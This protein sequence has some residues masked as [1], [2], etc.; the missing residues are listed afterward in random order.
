MQRD[1]LIFGAAHADIYGDVAFDATFTRSSIKKR[2]GNVNFSLG[3]TGFNV[4]LMLGTRRLPVSL[5]YLMNSHYFARSLVE[6]ELH[7]YDVR[8]VPIYSEAIPHVFYISHRMFSEDGMVHTHMAVC[9]DGL[10]DFPVS[11][12]RI[13]S[14]IRSAKTWL[15]SFNYRFAT[16]AELLRSAIYEKKII[17]LAGVGEQVVLNALQIPNVQRGHYPLDT[18]VLTHNELA[19]LTGSHL[20]GPFVLD[21]KQL[22]QNVGKLFRVLPL[23]A[24]V[25]TCGKDG[26][27]VATRN[28]FYRHFSSPLPPG[29]SVSGMGDAA[30]AATVEFRHGGSSIEDQSDRLAELIRNNIDTVAQ[31]ERPNLS[32]EL[33]GQLGHIKTYVRSKD[34]DR[35][36]RFAIVLSAIMMIV[37]T[38]LGIFV[39]LIS[40]VAV[41]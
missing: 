11:V 26:F 8:G 30:V 39:G 9:N 13:P 35:S 37:G 18:I 15:F 33:I 34:A 29:R 1:I 25:V 24:A 36:K 40:K 23:H 22:C 41:P 16:Y 17:I 10:V 7:K 19:S 38:A 5:T 12:A 3:G 31:Q 2:M 21:T 28:G 6:S 4:A 27:V 20:S 14:N 32:E